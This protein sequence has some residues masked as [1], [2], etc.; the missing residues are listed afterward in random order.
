VPAATIDVTGEDTAIKRF[1]EVLGGKH[2]EHYGG[3]QSDS[4]TIYRGDEW[5]DE[6]GEQDSKRDSAWSPV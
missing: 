5:R 4:E 1:F 3:P 6:R 2:Y